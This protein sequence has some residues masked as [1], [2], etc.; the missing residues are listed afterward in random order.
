[1]EVR[2]PTPKRGIS[3]ILARYPMKTRQMG[4]IPPSAI[5]PLERVLRDRGG[6]SPWAAKGG[7]GPLRECIENLHG[8]G[9]G[10][11]GPHL[12]VMFILLLDGFKLGA[13]CPWPHTQCDHVAG[14]GSGRV[15]AC[16]LSRY[17]VAR[18]RLPE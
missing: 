17:H 9:G 13:R 15:S 5:L 6:I 14:P 16:E 10:D 2:Y 7:P 1:M 3:A 4:A 8:G 12:L 18:D 11:R